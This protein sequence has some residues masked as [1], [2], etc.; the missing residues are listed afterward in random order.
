MSQAQQL[1]DQAE[2][3]LARWRAEHAAKVAE[4]ERVASMTDL[5]LDADPAEASV[6]TA[7]QVLRLSTEVD[8]AANAVTEAE[9]RVDEARRAVLRERAADLA[10]R[11]DRLRE[12][13]AE[14]QART[15]E[16][17]DAL[18]EHE[19]A[20]YQS[21]DVAGRA[22]ALAGG[23]ARTWAVPWTTRIRQAVEVLDGQAAELSR[24]AD[25]GTREQ[26]PHYLT[27]PVPVLLPVEERFVES[28]PAH[29]AA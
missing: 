5:D 24:Q 7:E 12:V 15:D 1:L 10:A 23:G 13:A 22:L 8:V 3:A 19:G 20:R 2:A 4:V 29:T 18:E 6:R 27:R 28:M 9:N 16:L 11:A 25:T 17:L 26:V 21:P 14:R